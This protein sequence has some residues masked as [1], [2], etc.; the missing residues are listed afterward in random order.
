MAGGLQGFQ[1]LV[2]KYSVGVLETRR[3]GRLPA[4]FIGMCIGQ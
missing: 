4:G 3:K 1:H 2:S